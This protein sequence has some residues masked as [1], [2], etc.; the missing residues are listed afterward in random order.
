MYYTSVIEPVYLFDNFSKC[1]HGKFQAFDKYEIFRML[2]IYDK[3]YTDKRWFL[4]IARRFGKDEELN[5]IFNNL[6]DREIIVDIPF[7]TTFL[8]YINNTPSMP[9]DCS[10][11]LK[12][13][14]NMA[15][16]LLKRLHENDR[17]AQSFELLPL[18]SIYTHLQFSLNNE[19][20][21][22]I[23]MP[24]LLI[25]FTKSLEPDKVS[26]IKDNL[27]IWNI[28]KTVLKYCIPSLEIQSFEQYEKF[29]E[30][31]DSGIKIMQEIIE[32][33]SEGIGS[34]IIRENEL[35]K[36][37]EYIV[38]S[39]QEFFSIKN[40]SRTVS[41]GSDI[42]TDIASL[43]VTL[44]IGTIKTKIFSMLE[45]RDIKS[46]N[47]SWVIY[48]HSLK[49]FQN[50]DIKLEQCKLCNLS[51]AELDNMTEIEAENILHGMN[52]C[53]GHNI[54]Y[55]NVRKYFPS[56]GADLIRLIKENENDKRFTLN[57]PLGMD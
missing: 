31:R 15:G 47:L 48:V 40:H 14:T 34:Y 20:F 29:L 46:R 2:S 36:V 7:E 56:H 57:T 16:A 22:F 53:P 26:T 43:I 35:S 33:I 21:L 6:F 10:K 41:L 25:C 18:Q 51:I 42:V 8:K 50:K 39:E 1:M 45:N 30:I 52:F 55:L 28:N 5:E 12:P 27:K 38:K 4:E 49:A 3:I 19:S 23:P 37:H 44:P 32:E 24:E 13:G 11:Y 9:L 54:V 17:I